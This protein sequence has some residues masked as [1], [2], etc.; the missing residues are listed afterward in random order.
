MRL[1]VVVYCFNT[2]RKE[3]NTMKKISKMFPFI[4]VIVIVGAVFVPKILKE[5]NVVDKKTETMTLQ[6]LYKDKT[7]RKV[8]NTGKHATSNNYKIETEYYLSVNTSNTD[9]DDS[10]EKVK[11]GQ[12]TWEDVNEGDH[13]ICDVTTKTYKDGSKSVSVTTNGIKE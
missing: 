10:V 8:K 2:K 12:S 4:L 7:N 5:M 9:D 11:V 1:N 3:E 6:V 13:I